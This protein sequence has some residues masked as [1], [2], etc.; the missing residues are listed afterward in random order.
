MSVAP[1]PHKAP[2][3]RAPSGPALA[4]ALAV[5]TAAAIG[6]AILASNRLQ[7]VPLHDA[8]YTSWAAVRAVGA[9]CLLFGTWGLGVVRL[10]LP[11]RLRRYE[12]LWVLPVGACSS[13]LVLTLLGFAAVPFVPNLV[14]TL[15]AGAGLTLVALRRRGLP[16]GPGI[17]GSLS[18]YLA[19]MLAAA[20]LFPYVLAGFPTVIGIGS[21]A[22]MAAGTAE[23]LRHSYPTSVN[24]RL[25]I[26]QVWVQWRSKP[27]IYYSLGAV[28][29]LSDLETWQAL[30][31]VAA[32]MLGL[33]GIGVFL[34]ARELLGG[35]VV[36]ALAAMVAAGFD[37][38]V[39]HTGM[40]PYFNQTWGY[41]AMWF[42]LV[43][44]WWAVRERSRGAV[45]LLAIFLA[46]EAFAYPLALPIPVLAL[47]IFYALDLRERRRRGEPGPAAALR[48]LYRGRRS[49]V[50]LIPVGLLLAVPVFGVGEKIVSGA[51]VVLD[52]TASLKEWGGDLFDYVPGEQFFAVPTSH[53]WWLAVLGMA[54]LAGLALR[55]VQ[56]ELAI[57]LGAVL[58][59]FIAAGAYFRTRNYGWY[60]EFKALAFVGPLLVACACVGT[61]RLRRAGP[62][63]L[64]L[65]VLAA[66]AS[67]KQEVR[68]TGHQLE[69]SEIAL[70]KFDRALPP[71]ASV[72]LDMA[73]NEQIWVAYMMSG[74]PLCSRLPLLG[75][76][77][78]RVRYSR[79][80]DYI[81]FDRDNRAGLA[82]PDDAAPGP[83]VLDNG[84]FVLYRT[85]KPLRGPGNCS[86]RM[87]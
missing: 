54:I 27:P 80:A 44:S 35:G 7:A 22:H 50:W 66:A 5:G 15:A 46:I 1:P 63:L 58:V 11:E 81:L 73:P 3:T 47:A 28:S 85:R 53:L 79:I 56:R 32:L 37:R 48:R 77:Y 43:L 86:Q 13:A 2:R 42:S 49:L 51:G 61:A 29:T 71:G 19:A 30:A 9:A 69:R 8:V 24:A 17:A 36:T 6:L 34:L 23:F 20:A 45:G 62:V 76:S 41:F 83:P 12:L 67:G 52:P 26:D 72:R 31:P 55:R 75:T 78:P 25:P 84:R 18:L 70:R 68:V 4:A 33:A 21:D 74:Q 59:V 87:V 65:L 38:M 60:F 39:L 40:H 64:A 82:R 14:V 10:L 16:A 57:G